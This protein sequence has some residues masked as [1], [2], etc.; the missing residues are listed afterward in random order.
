[1]PLSTL[2]SAA[3]ADPRPAPSE[4]YLL[5]VDDQPVERLMI[6]R[7]VEQLTGSAVARVADGREALDRIADGPPTAVLTDL[8]MPGM[9]GLELVQ[10]VRE[11]HPEVPVVLMTAFG[12]EEIAV[13]A[14]GAGAAGYV[15]KRGLEAALPDV[16]R[17]VLAIAA[18]NRRRRRLVGH[19]L[20]R[21]SHFLLDNDPDL[22]T[23]L[24]DQL[25]DDLASL[26]FDDAT[27]R[28]RLGV[29]LHE[30]L[31]N[32]H[33]HG[34]LEV[35]SD[36]RQ[37]DERR[38]YDL[39]ARRRDS[40]PYRDRH[41]EVRARVDPREARF[42]I[43]DDGPGFDTTILDRPID[44][45]DLTRVGGRGLLLI[46]SFVDEVSFNPAGNRITLLCRSRR[47]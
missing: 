42:E 37:E 26:G 12:S 36:L 17:Q 19:T 27:A 45:E 18:A 2:E 46:R 41:I 10:A 8:Q 43:A 9:G 47:R 39:A 34:N 5:V 16:L 31:S 23:P 1:M 24:I 28:M 11:R 33:Y 29:A 13:R 40:P 4:G 44:P 21:D 32:A 20:R 15:P 14:L 3:V 6:G 25:L 7:L 30:A 22:L 38:F 35:S